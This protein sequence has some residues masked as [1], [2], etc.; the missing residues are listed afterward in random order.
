MKRRR[1]I[2]VM[3]HWL[4]LNC[5][6]TWLKRPWGHKPG[7]IYINSSQCHPYYVYSEEKKVGVEVFMILGSIEG[8][9]Q[10]GI[11]SSLCLFLGEGSEECLAVWSALLRNVAPGYSPEKCGTTGFQSCV[12]S[13]TSFP[14]PGSLELL[15]FC[16]ARSQHNCL[17]PPSI[18]DCLS[19]CIVLPTHSLSQTYL[20]PTSVLADTAFLCSW[21]KPMYLEA[22]FVLWELYNFLQP[23]P[24]SIPK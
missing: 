19:T 8:Q 20:F 3:R 16:P 17:P 1:R 21:N 13:I 5:L 24:G 18:L 14:S 6:P 7:Q 23:T 9:K 4:C 2:S 22:N 12:C 15:S 11:N 10:T